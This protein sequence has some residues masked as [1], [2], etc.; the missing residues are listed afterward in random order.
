MNGNKLL[1][2]TNQIS[3]LHHRLLGTVANRSEF[4][5]D[6]QDIIAFL[7]RKWMKELDYRLIVLIETGNA[8]R[9]DKACLG[10]LSPGGA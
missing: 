8:G 9:L 4:V 5:T 2:V 7:T 1:Q 6:R 3:D 10:V